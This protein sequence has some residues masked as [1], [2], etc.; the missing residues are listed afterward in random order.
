[1]SAIAKKEKDYRKLVIQLEKD[2]LVRLELLGGDYTCKYYTGMRNGWIR[3]TLKKENSNR[4]YETLIIKQV[5]GFDVD[6]KDSGKYATRNINT[7]ANNRFR[8]DLIQFGK[9]V[10]KLSCDSQEDKDKIEIYLKP[11]ST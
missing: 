8:I 9:V 6:S 5:V 1:M 2:N 11:H 7:T 3:V 10:C 4:D